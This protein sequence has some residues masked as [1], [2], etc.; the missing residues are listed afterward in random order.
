[1]ISAGKEFDKL[2]LL[3]NGSESLLRGQYKVSLLDPD[4]NRLEERVRRQLE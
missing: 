4:C 3:F 1:M 2:V